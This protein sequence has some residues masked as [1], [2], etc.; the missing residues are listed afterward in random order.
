MKNWGTAIVPLLFATSLLAFAP[1]GHA[2]ANN[3]TARFQV[4]ETSVDAIQAA[5]KTGE[6]TAHQLLVRSHERRGRMLDGCD[7]REAAQHRDVGGVRVAR[8]LAPP[9]ASGLLVF[10]E[11]REVVVAHSWFDLSLVRLAWAISFV[12]RRCLRRNMF[13]NRA[14]AGEIAA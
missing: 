6:L 10:D 1:Q 3:S 4:M 9:R 11:A 8:G 14:R 5:Y 2:Q 7:A 13:A 12:R